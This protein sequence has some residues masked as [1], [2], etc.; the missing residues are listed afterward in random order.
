MATGV[1]IAGR[2][3][4]LN[5]VAARN[6]VSSF[7]SLAWLNLLSMLVI[8]IY[9][10]L[11]GPTSWGIIA[12]CS[13]LQ[14]MFTFI[15]LGFS[16]I[17]PRWVARESS[18]TEALRR[19][20]RVFQKIYGG[21]ALGGFMILQLAAGPLASRWFNVP[22]EQMPR[23]ELCIRLIAFQ[24]LFQF[25]NNL[26]VSVWHGLQLQIQANLRT[27]L[28]GTLKHGLAVAVLV[29]AAPVPTY[30]ACAFSTVAFAELGTSWWVTRRR[31]LL[32]AVAGEDLPLRPFLKEA[33]MLSA[34]IIVGLS[35]SQLDR[36]V[37]S[38]TVSVESF[39]IYV[40]VANLAM[41]FL[42][43]QAPLTRA[44]F[45]LL[46]QE[47]KQLGRV[48]PATL[49]RLLLGNTAL[50]VIP[51]LLVAVWA[52]QV[53][54]LWVHNARFV[55]LGVAPLRL[56]LVAMCFNALYN[57]F[58]QVIIAYGRAHLI[59]KINAICLVMGIATTAA[60]VSHPAL[61]L[62]GLI[63]A[64]TAFTQLLLGCGWYWSDVTRTQA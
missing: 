45:P 13:S 35:V 46:A 44:Y 51:A 18:D 36:I 19:Y 25:A 37:L 20:I 6:A 42:A 57:C 52:E 61:W 58:Y 40:V 48:H 53:L 8:P 32:Q 60:F 1:G 27:C 62:G 38:R 28:F 34:G 7:I 11:L 43:L 49:R 39:G 5:S 26:Y 16:Q 4:L 15:D 30:Y 10:R 2:F 63:W 9:V 3:G 56:L 12:A 22:Q 47:A 64:V 54:R 24:L 21:L 59:I 50:C 41:A 31:G 33:A 55:E 17:V 29:Y 23:L 14:L